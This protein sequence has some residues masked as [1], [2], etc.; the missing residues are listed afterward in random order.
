M[1]DLFD[2]TEKSQ[3]KINA[4]CINTHQIKLDKCGQALSD[5]A[6]KKGQLSDEV[7]SHGNNCLDF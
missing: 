5:D 2:S 6:K 4:G 7:V 3:K 1:Y